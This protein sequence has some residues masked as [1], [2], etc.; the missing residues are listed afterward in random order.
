MRNLGES[1]GE[2]RREGHEGDDEEARDEIVR[3]ASIALVRP[4]VQR[5]DTETSVG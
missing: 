5:C 2:S 3:L 1:R 4:S